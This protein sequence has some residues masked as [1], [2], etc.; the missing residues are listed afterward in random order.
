MPDRPRRPPPG[1]EDPPPSQLQPIWYR[2]HPP[3]SVRAAIEAQGLKWE[4]VLEELRRRRDA[5]VEGEEWDVSFENGQIMWNKP[6]QEMLKKRFANEAYL[7]EWGSGW[8]KGVIWAIWKVLGSPEGVFETEDGKV[9]GKLV[10]RQLI[11]EADE[12][13]EEPK[14][15]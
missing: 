15:G 10:L 3:E 12:K 8:R 1:F 14:K 2:H 5:M 13:T 11:K 7:R 6:S 9:D 4:T